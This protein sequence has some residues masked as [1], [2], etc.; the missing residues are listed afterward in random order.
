MS[1]HRRSALVLTVLAL[2]SLLLTGAAI[3]GS[4]KKHPAASREAAHDCHE[5]AGRASPG[6]QTYAPTTITRA[7]EVS[8]VKLDPLTSSSSRSRSTAAA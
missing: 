2:T 7:A 6:A 4:A 8:A 1:Q 3:A 5:E